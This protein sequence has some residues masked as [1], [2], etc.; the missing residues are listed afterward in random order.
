MR[1]NRDLSDTEKFYFIRLVQ[2]GML[3]KGHISTSDSNALETIS[4]ALGVNFP[5]NRRPKDTDPLALKQKRYLMLMTGLNTEARMKVAAYEKAHGI[6]S[7]VDILKFESTMDES[8]RVGSGEIILRDSFGPEQ[9]LISQ[10]QQRYQSRGIIDQKDYDKFQEISPYLEGV[11]KIS[12]EG[13]LP[14]GSTAD[15]SPEPAQSKH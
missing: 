15:G 7:D 10:F 5:P 3:M 11:K 12:L 1:L 2:A 4:I 8:L 9:T 14:A 6:T 13:K